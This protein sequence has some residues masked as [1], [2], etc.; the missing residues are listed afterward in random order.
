VVLVASYWALC[1]LTSRSAIRSLKTT[2]CDPFA[3]SMGDE[4]IRFADYQTFRQLCAP[5]GAMSRL[6][7]HQL[8]LSRWRSDSTAPRRDG[9][10]HPR[11]VEGVVGGR[12][13][14]HS[15]TLSKGE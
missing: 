6:A 8:L 4:Q 14:D 5:V 2:H 7:A 15:N 10:R 13:G 11:A 1:R 9:G 12:V 3:Q